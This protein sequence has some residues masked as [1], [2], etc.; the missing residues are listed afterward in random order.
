M[1]LDRSAIVAQSSIAL[2]LGPDLDRCNDPGFGQLGHLGG[3]GGISLGNDELTLFETDQL[4]Q[5]G[6]RGDQGLQRLMTE[7]DSVEHL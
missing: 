7:E 1:L 4:G 5:F 3:Q 6:L 2:L